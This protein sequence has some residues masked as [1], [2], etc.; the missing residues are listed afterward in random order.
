MVKV[1]GLPGPER[2]I[3]W[4]GLVVCEDVLGVISSLEVLGP[5]AEV[6]DND[7]CIDIGIEAI[8]GALLSMVLAVTTGAAVLQGQ[9]VRIAFTKSVASLRDTKVTWKRR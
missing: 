1:P 9:T 4:D 5:R 7:G 6:R 8:V 2:S 3:A